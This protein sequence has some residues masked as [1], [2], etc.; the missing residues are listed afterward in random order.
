[1]KLVR[2]KQ[3]KVEREREER[4]KAERAKVSGEGGGWEVSGEVSPERSEQKVPYE[5]SETTERSDSSERSENK[6]SRAKR[7]SSL[8]SAARI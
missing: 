4:D 7:A 6:L 3:A 5:R 8:P 1:L 2:E